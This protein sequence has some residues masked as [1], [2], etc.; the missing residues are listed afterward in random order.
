MYREDTKLEQSRAHPK[1]FPWFGL[2]AAT[3]SQAKGDTAYAATNSNITWICKK[4]KNNGGKRKKSSKEDWQETV[5][6]Y[7]WKDEFL[8]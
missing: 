8:F 7:V 6:Q 2:G 4:A 5:Y 1:A 3:C